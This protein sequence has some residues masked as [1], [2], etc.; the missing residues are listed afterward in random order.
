MIICQGLQI[1]NELEWYGAGFLSVCLMMMSQ[2][3]EY[4]RL[5]VLL[6]KSVLEKVFVTCFQL[7]SSYVGSFL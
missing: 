7:V 5:F 2:G 6:S 4:L 1:K 3:G